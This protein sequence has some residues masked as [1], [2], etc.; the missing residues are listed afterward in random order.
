L[1]VNAKSIVTSQVI[2]G[3]GNDQMITWYLVAL[4]TDFIRVFRNIQENSLAI[5]VIDCLKS[6]ELAF[7]AEPVCLSGPFSSWTSGARGG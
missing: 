2:T 1:S 5:L 7:P 4:P 3:G 6:V